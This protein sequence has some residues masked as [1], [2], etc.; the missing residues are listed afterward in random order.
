MEASQAD[1]GDGASRQGSALLSGGMSSLAQPTD[2]S[3]LAAWNSALT[4]RDI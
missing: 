1:V 3:M 2:V 4:S